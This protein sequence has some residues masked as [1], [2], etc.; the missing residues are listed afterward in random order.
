MGGSTQSSYRPA[1]GKIRNFPPQD[2]QTDDTQFS[3]EYIHQ[4]GQETGYFLEQEEELTIKLQQL[5]EEASL[6]IHV[7]RDTSQFAILNS[8][9]E[10]AKDQLKQTLESRQS[11]EAHSM[12]ALVEMKDKIRQDERSR[13]DMLFKSN[14]VALLRALDL[15]NP[16]HILANCTTMEEIA[17][18]I[19]KRVGVTGASPEPTKYGMSTRTIKPANEEIEDMTRENKRL[20]ELVVKLQY[21]IN[22][23]IK[24]STEERLK[25]LYEDINNYQ[26]KIADLIDQLKRKEQE[27]LLIPVGKAGQTRIDALEKE[28]AALLQIIEDMKKKHAEEVGDLRE[29]L[30]LAGQRKTEFNPQMPTEVNLD[31]AMFTTILDQKQCIENLSETLQKLRHERDSYEQTLKGTVELRVSYEE[32]CKKLEAYLVSQ[33]VNLQELVPYLFE[34]P[35]GG[36][37]DEYEHDELDSFEK[38]KEIAELKLQ[39]EQMRQDMP[40]NSA[41]QKPYGGMGNHTSG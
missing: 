23:N 33:G 8:L 37:A 24:K 4:A 34:A 14:I 40:Y 13:Y 32:Y 35:P 12:A 19:R 17:F 2:M 15:P 41:P 29:K 20:K 38:K 21:E 10:Q 30:R 11:M 27:I 9:N 31:V 39:M 25:I 28:K 5:L 26:R 3:P 16:E 1:S 6:V 7:P 18:E 22:E 36:Y